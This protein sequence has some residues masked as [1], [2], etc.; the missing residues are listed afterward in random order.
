M[1]ADPFDIE[2]IR[3]CNPAIGHFL[4]EPDL[5]EDADMARGSYAFEPS[6]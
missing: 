5:I 4:S 6:L 1:D 2:T 3:A